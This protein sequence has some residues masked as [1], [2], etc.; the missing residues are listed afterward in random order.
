MLED[1]IQQ[2]KAA[3]PEEWV[4]FSFAILQVVFAYLNK[5]INFLFGAISVCFYTVI[6]HNKELPAESILNAYY[7]IVSIYGLFLWN[8]K[9]GKEIVIS[10]TNKR[11]WWI[12]SL[13]IIACFITFICIY[14]FREVNF[15]IPFGAINYAD[16]LAAALAFGGTYLLIKRN[17]ETWI[18]LNISNLIA[19]PV[20]WSKGLYLTS[21][22]TFILFSVAVA[23]YFKWHKE[24]QISK[25]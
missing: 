7:L 4:A 10:K 25:N 14:Y 5:P 23:A 3:Q 20:Q 21:V 1:L 13:I 16:A 19:M 9:Q 18:I 11:N 12:T 6:F 15:D 8:K 22:L 2:F 24:M 17:I